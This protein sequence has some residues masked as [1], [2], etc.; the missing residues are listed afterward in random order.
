MEKPDDVLGSIKSFFGMTDEPEP[1]PEPPA[2][3]TPEEEPPAP[4]EE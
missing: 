1:E 3:E 2:E 4:A